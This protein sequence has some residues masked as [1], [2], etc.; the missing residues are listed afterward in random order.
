[1][2]DRADA[3]GTLINKAIDTRF[4]FLGIGLPERLTLKFGDVSK[5]CFLDA[6]GGIGAFENGFLH[7]MPYQVLVH[8]LQSFTQLFYG[9]IYFLTAVSRA[10]GTLL[11]VEIRPLFE[12][13]PSNSSIANVGLPSFFAGGGF[14]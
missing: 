4:A 12:V 14:G 10:P 6:P 1:M 7:P 9:T 3:E 13:L 8:Q 2:A 5:N 11:V